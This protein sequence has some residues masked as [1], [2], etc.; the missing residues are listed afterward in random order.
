MYAPSGQI[1]AS[2]FHNYP[3]NLNLNV[4]VPDLELR[5][6]PGQPF[7]MASKATG[8]SEGTRGNLKYIGKK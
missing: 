5:G 3:R 8:L 6:E 2:P 4:K 7:I 1:T